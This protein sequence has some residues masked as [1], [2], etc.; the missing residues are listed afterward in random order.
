[1]LTGE[2][3]LSGNLELKK[4]RLEVQKRLKVYNALLPSDTGQHR[5]FREIFLKKVE[6]C[7]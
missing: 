5:L 1:M 4:E 3:Y 6:N 7:N 2:L